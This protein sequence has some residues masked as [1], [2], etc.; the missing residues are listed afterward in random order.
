[1]TEPALERVTFGVTTDKLAECRDFYVRLFGFRV[2][3]EQAWFVHLRSAGGECEIGLLQ[4]DRPEVPAAFG[5]RFA[6]AGAWIS[7]N[8]PDVQQVLE[9]CRSLGIPP[10][11]DVRDEPWGERHF[12]VRDPAGVLVNIAQRIPPF[13]DYARSTGNGST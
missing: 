12:G 7:F 4:P 6:G 11:F 1:V 9:R 10:D 3:F 13:G 2:V 5:A 8:V